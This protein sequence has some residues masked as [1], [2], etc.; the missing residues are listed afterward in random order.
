MYT[1][2]SKLPTLS[3]S[4]DEE[5]THRLLTYNDPEAREKL[6]L[7]HLR[8]VRYMVK[9]YCKYEDDP[10]IDKDDLFH[11][12]I[13]G[14][15]EA[16]DTFSHNVNCNLRSYT[17]F[18]IRSSVQRALFKVIKLD[19]IAYKFP[20]YKVWLTSVYNFWEFCPR[21]PSILKLNLTRHNDFDNI[22]DNFRRENLERSIEIWDSQETL[23]KMVTKLV[24]NQL[25]SQRDVDVV[26]E[27]YS[28]YTYAE[29]GKKYNISR[30]RVRQIM[31][32]L[33]RRIAWHLGIKRERRWE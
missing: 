31:Q 17:Y 28:G 6:I 29:I 5:L 3:K 9:S 10:A 20:V 11:D 13:V 24:D 25:V 7:H 27:C 12:D 26:L 32:N 16:I 30:E 1:Y 4:E 15:L 23:G 33:P 21:L 22:E 19:K 2:D 14:L 18:K 8:F